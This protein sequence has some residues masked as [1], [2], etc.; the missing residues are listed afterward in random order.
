MSIINW[1]TIGD[2]ISKLLIFETIFFVLCYAVGAWYGEYHPAAFGWPALATLGTSAILRAL[3]GHGQG[4]LSR[5][6][7]FLILAL[8]WLVFSVFGML[9]YLISGAVPDVSDAFFETMSGFTTTGASVLTHIEDLPHSILFWR[10]LTQWVGG[11][12]IV[13]FTLA[14][15]PS[16]GSGDVRLFSGESTGF[17]LGKLHARFS[18]TTK[19]LWGIYT[20][21]TLACA[22]TLWV[23]GMQ[24]FDAL[25]HALTTA[26]SGGFSTKQASIEAFQ[27]PAVEYV[28]SIFMFLAA[29][30]FGLLY[31]LFIKRDWR[32]LWRDTEFRTY[33]AICV[34]FTLAIA[35]Y[36]AWT[37]SYPIERAFRQALFHVTSLQSSTGFT[38][39]DIDMWPSFTVVLFLVLLTLGGSAG[40]TAGGYKCIRLYVAYQYARNEMMHL[41]HPRAYLRIN[42]G[43]KEHSKVGESLVAF[44][45]LFIVLIFIGTTS[46]VL[47]GDPLIDSLSIT[48]SSLSNAGPALGHQFGANDGWTAL[49]PAGKWLSSFLMLA[50]RLEIFGI[51][52]PLYA[53]FWMND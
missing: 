26:A 24:P 51:L 42:V 12:G 11:L 30:N 2:V 25:C 34:G 46:F 49:Q 18:T 21:L 36:M 14:I 23:V 17:K 19:W 39:T 27:L 5:R 10:S 4:Q 41:L 29:V 22:I 7:A 38:T 33:A 50:G 43:G 53:H 13:F 6:D 15:L 9:P 47:M 35:S 32:S 1:R 8:A 16:L 37:Q 44:T 52:L 20:S 48:I 31:L 40:S 28:L 45:F 3:G